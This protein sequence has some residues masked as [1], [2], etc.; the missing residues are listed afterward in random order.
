MHTEV[1]QFILF[2]SAAV[3]LA[4]TPGCDVMFIASQSLIHRKNGILAVLGTST[5]IAI[6]ILLSVLGLTIALQHSKVLYNVIKMSGAAYLLYLAWG[7]FFSKHNIAKHIKASELDGFNSYYKGLITNILNPKI[8]I[9]FITFLPQFVNARVEH[10]HEQLLA[11]GGFFLLIGGTIN[12][13]YVLLFFK[14]K[15]VLLS[16]LGFTKWLDKIISII[17][18]LMALKVLID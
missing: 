2:A 18:C 3:M 5:G 10:V 16:K 12:I 4:L 17:F 8:G 9:F 1:S 6:Y 11:L 14:F 15:D 7:A 13:L